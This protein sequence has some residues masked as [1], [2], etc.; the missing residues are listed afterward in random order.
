[1]TSFSAV[2][3]DSTVSMELA[4]SRIIWGKVFNS[5]QTCIA[6]DYVLCTLDVQN[7]LLEHCSGVLKKFFGSDVSKSPDY[8]RIISDKQFQ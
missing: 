6:P 7:R 4:A 2:Y 3:I 5:G 8:P 1:M